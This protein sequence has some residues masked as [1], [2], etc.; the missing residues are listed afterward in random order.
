MPGAT[1]GRRPANPRKWLR[2]LHAWVGLALAALLLLFVVTGFLLNHR[3]VMKIPALEKNEAVVVLPLA[4][5]PATPEALVAT[6]A[7]RFGFAPE[8]LLIRREA[9]REVEWSG[10]RI[11]QPERW[12]IAADQPS[13][14]LRVDYWAGSRQAEVRLATPNLWLRLARLHMAIGSGPAWILLADAL[15]VGL[16]FLAGSGFWL[17]GRLHGSRR[18]LIGVAGAGLLLALLLGGLAG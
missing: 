1:A 2:R 9:A 8:S 13:R 10:Q 5:V 12:I 14:S 18:A 11:A 16:V 7:G 15:V 3:A 17:W 4:V 6:V